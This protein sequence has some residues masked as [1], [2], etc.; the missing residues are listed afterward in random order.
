MW[1]VLDDVFD[2]QRAHDLDDIVKIVLSWECD[3][4]GL[5]TAGIGHQP[6]WKKHKSARQ[7]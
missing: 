4:E 7:Q 1:C 2:P 6:D 3:L 5:V